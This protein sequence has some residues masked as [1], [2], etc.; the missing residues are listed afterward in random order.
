MILTQRGNMMMNAAIVCYLMG[1]AV[2]VKKIPETM[3]KPL[4][5]YSYLVTR[6]GSERPEWIYPSL[7]V[8][9]LTNLVFWQ[10]PSTVNV[11][12]K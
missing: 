4:L 2:K 7:K 5:S 3:K 11:E 1:A 10:A 12:L 8:M 9:R 6:K